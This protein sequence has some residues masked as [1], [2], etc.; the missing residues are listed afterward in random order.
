MT[1]IKAV[2]Q[3]AI[4]DVAESL[5]YSFRRLSG[6]IYEHPDHDSFRI[7]ADTNTFKWFSRDIQGDVIDFVQLVAGV[8]FKEAVS[9]LETGDFE[10]AKVIEE[11]YQPFQYYL[12]E[13]PF[14]QART[15]LNEVRGLSNQTIN[16]FGRQGLLAQAT[17]QV[18]SVLVFKSY[19]HNGILQ[20]ASLQ[21]LVKNEERHKRGYLKK[22]MKGSH[23]HVGIS[24]D[25]GKPKRL[26]FCESVIDM[27]SYYQ[28]YQKQLSDVRLVSMEGLKLS[29]IVYQTLRLAAEEQG[30]LTFLDTVKPS[31]LNHYLQAIQET[32][33]FFQ[34]H[35]NGLTLA[36]DNDEAGREFFQKLSDK[37]LPITKDLPPLQGLETKS[38][39][40]DIVKQQKE[41]S[42]S[43]LIQSAHIQAIKNHP[44]PKWEHAL[45][46]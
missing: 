44:P 5:G 29:V 41:I 4:I 43:N 36:I 3:K 39:W 30:K 22:I 9:Y 23:G 18:E 13:E 33:T 37:G 7:F 38:D 17:Y 40:N 27:M 16:T 10:Q 28:L 12:H 25:I 26:I 11:T 6:H 20:A 8:T 2:K 45:E 21:G 34:T 31:R 19:D 24:F 46:L 35:S 32:T 15:Y 1:R 42:L 14:Q